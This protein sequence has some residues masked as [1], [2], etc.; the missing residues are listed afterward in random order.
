MK[1]PFFDES[2]MGVVSEME[3]SA[4]YLLDLY[5]RARGS[6]SYKNGY[7]YGQWKEV[8]KWRYEPQAKGFDEASK[9]LQELK[10]L[11]RQERDRLRTLNKVISK[12]GIMPVYGL[13]E[14]ILNILARE[15]VISEHGMLTGTFSFFAYQTALG[16]CVEKALTR[17]ADVDP[18]RPPE[19]QV[20]VKTLNLSSI[21]ENLNVPF[22]PD[23][24][25]GKTVSPLPC[26]AKFK[27]SGVRDR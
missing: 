22:V 27:L 18:V 20:M 8:N 12:K 1:S 11:Y 13:P 19:L 6:I 7:V 21:L 10:G 26:P 5:C 17:P 2:I 23:G 24:P 4:F 16:F 15:G 25:E 9:R 14:R 3:T